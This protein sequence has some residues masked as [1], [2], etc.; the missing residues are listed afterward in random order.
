MAQEDRTV[1]SNPVNSP[2]RGATLIGTRS[3]N[4]SHV[5]FGALFYI[6]QQY[7]RFC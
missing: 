6:V 1:A 4:G 3:S 5:C 7:T 2:L